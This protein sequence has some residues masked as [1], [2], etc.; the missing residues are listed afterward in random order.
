MCLIEARTKLIELMQ[1]VGRATTAD[2]LR[3]AVPRFVKE[4]I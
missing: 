3:R 1:T 4:V 2:E